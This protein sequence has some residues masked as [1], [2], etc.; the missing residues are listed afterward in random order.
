MLKRHLTDDPDK[1]EDER[2]RVGEGF[3][4]TVTR[5]VQPRIS[6]AAAQTRHEDEHEER[7]VAARVHQELDERT[8]QAAT[9]LKQ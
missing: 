6:A 2:S 8:P 9:Q 1:N 5:H 3:G 7:D 4:E